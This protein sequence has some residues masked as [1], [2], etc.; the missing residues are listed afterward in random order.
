MLHFTG[1]KDTHHFIASVFCLI[2]ST[3]SLVL[4]VF[5]CGFSTPALKS[6]PAKQW[7]KTQT[8]KQ[9]VMEKYVATE[10]VPFNGVKPMKMLRI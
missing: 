8:K 3:A 10:A 2:R 6:I 5:L 7:I 9:R 4:T 1:R